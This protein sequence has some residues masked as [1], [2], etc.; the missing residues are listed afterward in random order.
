MNIATAPASPSD[1]NSP[2][3]VFPSP[4][5]LSAEDEKGLIDYAF[6]RLDELEKELGRDKCRANDWW[7]GNGGTDSIN[8][9]KKSFLGK[10]QVYELLY[11]NEVDWRIDVF[12]EIFAQSNFHLPVTRRVVTQ[13]VARSLLRQ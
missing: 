9:G 1:P 4:Y 2:Q 7:T 3:V 11:E 12:G 13:Q 8:Q 5:R 6:Q 10:R